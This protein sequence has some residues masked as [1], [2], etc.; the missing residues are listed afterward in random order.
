MTV[1]NMT[2]TLIHSKIRLKMK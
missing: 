1:L 2:M